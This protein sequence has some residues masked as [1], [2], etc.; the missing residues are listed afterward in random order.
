MAYRMGT[1]LPPAEP[2]DGVS[3][4]QWAEQLNA[5]LDGSVANNLLFRI[6]LLLGD[7]YFANYQQLEADATTNLYQRIDYRLAFLD[8]LREGQ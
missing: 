1:A 6:Q 3:A 5:W 8:K 2:P 7:E 4:A